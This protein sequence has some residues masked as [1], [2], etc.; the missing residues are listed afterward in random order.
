MASEVFKKLVFKGVEF[1]YPKVNQPYKFNTHEQRSEPCA[2]T[3]T[4]AAYSV[5][6]TISMEEAK[7]AAAELKQ[8]YEACRANDKKLPAFAKVFGFKKQEN[9]SVLV[10]AKKRA[11]TNAGDVAR[12]PQVVDG[13]LK[14]LERLDFWSGSKGSIRILAFP[15]K[16]PDGEGG[17]SLLLDVIQVT[18]PV[19]GDANSLAGDFGAVD[20]FETLESQ[21]T[22]PP[23]TG[24][25]KAAPPPFDP[26]D[27]GFG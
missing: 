10:T 17:I 9:G 16:S 5:G 26:D 7:K 12:P 4:G 24:S 6:F 22:K 27:V 1:Q 13:A 21:P 3:A 23:A 20:N 15:T 8:H 2:P 19:Y 11:V 14:P 25:R 18:E